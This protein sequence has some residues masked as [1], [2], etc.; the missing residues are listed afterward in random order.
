MNVTLQKTALCFLALAFGSAAMAENFQ[1]ITAR[2]NVQQEVAPDE[3]VVDGRWVVVGTKKQHAFG[4]DSDV[5]YKGKPSYRFFLDAADNTLQGYSAG[6]TKGRIELCGCYATRADVAKLTAEELKLEE[7]CKT[8]YHNGKGTFAQGSSC[9][10]RFAVYV[11]SA[12]SADVNTIFAQWHGMPSRTLVQT[13]EGEIKTITKAEFADLCQTMTFKK[14]EGV[15]LTTKKKNGWLVEQGGYPPLAFGFN[16]G[17]FYIKANSDRRWLSDKD[18]RC[19]VNV[20][21]GQV[22]V[23]RKSEYKESVLAYKLPYAEFPKDQWVEFD[24]D[25]TWSRYGKERETIE[26]AGKLDVKM[27]GKTIVDQQTLNIGRNDDDG[28]YFKFGIYRVGGSTEPVKY[29]LVYL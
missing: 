7:I 24:V 13:P 21:N 9:R 1:P 22:M 26:K 4:L 15:D 8:V 3:A 6:E 11:P 18:D 17:Y 28:Y 12:M 14:N 25:I 10:F 19:N 27:D 23:P 16:D 29:N 20:A 5:L 2:V